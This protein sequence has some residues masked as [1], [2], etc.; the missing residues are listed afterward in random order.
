MK[1]II[2]FY[3][4]LKMTTGCHALVSEPEHTTKPIKTIFTEKSNYTQCFNIP[5]GHR[6][7]FKINQSLPHLNLRIT[8]KLVASKIE[9]QFH[10]MDL[11]ADFLKLKIERMEFANTKRIQMHLVK[12]IKENCERILMALA[13]LVVIGKIIG[14]KNLILI[15][16]A[17]TLLQPTQAAPPTTI[18]GLYNTLFYIRFRINFSWLRS[19]FGEKQHKEM[20][21]ALIDA[22]IQL[23]HIAT[24]PPPK[25]T[26]A[27]KIPM[28]QTN[29]EQI[30]S[31][32]H[33]FV[34]KTLNKQAE[35]KEE[36]PNAAGLTKQQEMIYA[37]E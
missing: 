15:L 21:S 28:Y 7:T 20:E 10:Y 6:F 12:S 9:E 29:D 3:G 17:M 35:E 4:L 19:G 11:Y 34:N 36:A 25:P 5:S 37:T 24:P 30:H 14:Y 2:I 1:F 26:S 8:N 27:T 32:L 22:I 33:S 18:E 23:Q 16:F 31:I 13:L